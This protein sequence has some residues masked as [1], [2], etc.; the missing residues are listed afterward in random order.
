[1]GP[2]GNGVATKQLYHLTY[3]GHSMPACMVECL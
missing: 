2:D 3:G 1:M